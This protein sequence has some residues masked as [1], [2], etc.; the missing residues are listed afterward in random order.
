MTY[1][2]RN[3]TTGELRERVKADSAELLET[4]LEAASRA[5]RDW[6]RRSFTDRAT[7]LRGVGRRLRETAEQH[8]EL[9]ALEMGKPLAEGIGEARKCALLCDYYAEH[10][11][12]F[13]ARETVATSAR[14]SY[15][16]YDPLGPVLAVMPWNYPYWQVIRFAAPALMAGNVGLLKHAEN[17]PGCARAL[18]ALFTEAGF[19]EGCFTAL[20][21]TRDQAADVIADRRVA[22]VTLTGSTRAGATVAGLSGRALKK[23]VLELGGSDP[24]IV[25]GDADLEAAARTAATSRLLNSG[26]SCISA[27]RFIVQRSVYGDFLG[28]F[29]EALSGYEVGDPLDDETDIGPMARADLRDTLH[30]QVTRS[31]ESGARC[32]MGGAPGEG[33]GYFYPVSLLV[34]IP[35]GSAADTEELFGPVASVFSVEDEGEAIALANRSDYGLGATVF[36]ADLERAERIA[37]Q[38]EAGCVAIN[39][40]VRS[41][42]ELPFGG[43]KRSG[44]GRE[45]SSHGI[46]EF[47]N[48]KSVWI[49]GQT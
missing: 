47:V 17:V 35:R 11:E 44:Y 15:V 18:E 16:R 43:I 38:L 29:Q 25:L 3:P 6:R 19:P 33:A 5:A 27:K 31:L 49:G 20:F 10:A 8:A 32:L 21:I 45:L 30:D 42:P 41:T 39:D 14:K 9:M 48:T 46:R 7:L 12:A 2:S 24:F 4:R 13:L 37:G 1:E 28:R 40:F 23:T 22:A 36:S 26:Q 34:D